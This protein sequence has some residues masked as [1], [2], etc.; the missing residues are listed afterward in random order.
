MPYL[1]AVVKEAARYRTGSVI[2]RS[3]NSE[4]SFSNG[5]KVPATAD[6]PIDITLDLRSVGD[7]FFVEKNGLDEKVLR[8][9]DPERFLAKKYDSN[10]MGYQVFSKGPRDCIGKAFAYLS[11]KIQLIHLYRNFRTELVV[12]TEED[13]TLDRVN[14]LNFS[15]Q[16]KTPPIIK[17]IRREQ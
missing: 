13:R 3:A 17:F 1:D 2:G 7:S 9:F 12:T 4:I 11:M 16:F 8:T 6:H 14:V 15:F 10:T 5:F